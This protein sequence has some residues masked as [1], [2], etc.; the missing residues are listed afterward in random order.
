MSPNETKNAAAPAETV[1]VELLLCV[2]EDG[3]WQVGT[4]DD[5]LDTRW[6]DF[7]GDDSAPAPARRRVTVKLT[8]PLPKPVVL[9]GVVPEEPAGDAT[10]TAE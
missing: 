9:R 10:L 7:V 5:D 4:D 1:E 8:I 2:D 3:N 6:A